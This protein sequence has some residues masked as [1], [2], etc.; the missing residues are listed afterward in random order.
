MILAE[1]N[2]FEK[3]SL[4]SF[5]A[6]NEFKKTFP[7]RSKHEGY[8]ML[9]SCQE[10]EDV[11]QE[12]G[13]QVKK[14]RNSWDWNPRAKFV[15]LLMGI[16]DI[17]TKLLAEDIFAELW[18]SR[19]VNSVV[20]IPALDTHIATGTV[21]ILDAYIWFPYQPAGKC[22][23][24]KDA[25]LQNRWILDSNNTGYFMHNTSL[26]PQK[27]PRDIHG[28]PLA[29][30]TFELPPMI[31][32][33]KTTEVDPKNIIYDKGLEIY[34]LTE[35]AKSINSSLKFR[36][37]PPDGGN[38]GWD[39]GNG[40]WNG[41][42]GE[43]A[44]SYSDISACLLWYRCHLVKEIECL[45]PYIIDKVRW[46]VP[47]ARPYPRWMSL[48]RVFQMSLW[49]GFLTAYVIV[50]AIMWQ[51]VKISSNIFIEAAQNQ[52][53]AGFG[54]CF[55]N[56]WAIILEESA[57]NHPPNVAVIRA[58]FFAWVLY[59]WAVN[60]V[61]QAYLTSFLIEPGLQHQLSSEDEML[62]SGIQY[63]TETS[64]IFLYPVLKGTR[65]GHMSIVKE[66]ASAEKGVE[67][68]MLTFLFSM[69]LVQYHIALD[70]TDADGMPR[71]CYIE[72]DFA[73]TLMTMFV[74]KGFPFKAWYDQVLLYLMQAG[75]VNFWWEDLKYTATLEKAGD[76]NLPPGEY[77]TLTMEHLQSAF[78]FLLLGYAISVI[79]FLVELCQY[80]Q[81]YRNE[82]MKI[83]RNRKQRAT[84]TS[85][86]KNID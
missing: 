45:R 64:L 58:V 14:L 30:S 12:I 54:K 9:S 47:C 53:Y 24:V 10:Q 23:H 62:T 18:T 52:A 22:I 39:L 8:V 37:S 19:V 65:Y 48:T 33:K 34:I 27:I 55:L 38:W 20:L 63:S 70:Y 5:D 76:F 44:R 28:C 35:L 57:S 86:H 85:S 61:Y 13:E 75:L 51:V 46:Y 68:G 60:N 36:D 43:I 69:F 73:F 66:V 4:L 11:L 50:A 42:T 29:V 67:K 74:P 2:K 82:R 49:I 26:F 15:I 81:G 41:L 25:V 83:N 80:R 32:R 56:F 6:N 17:N 40:T 84:L 78:Y 31:M 71:I 16:R 79:S 7:S 21:N 1:F 77:I 59:C 3:W 72:D